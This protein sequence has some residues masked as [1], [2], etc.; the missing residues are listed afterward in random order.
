MSER[1]D[2]HRAIESL[3]DQIWN[4]R[5]IKVAWAIESSLGTDPSIECDKN[6]INSVYVEF[7]SKKVR[8]FV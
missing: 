7:H 3:H 8:R 4:G 2:A 5:R 1:G 6:A